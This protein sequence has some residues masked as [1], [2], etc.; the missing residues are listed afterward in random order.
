M[1]C[2]VATTVS[3]FSDTTVSGLLPESVTLNILPSNTLSI[4]DILLSK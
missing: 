1:I 2:P 4:F 3:S